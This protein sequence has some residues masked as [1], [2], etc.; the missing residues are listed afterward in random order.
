MS[1][2]MEVT[3]GKSAPPY[4]S[5]K[6]TGVATLIAITGGVPLLLSTAPVSAF[7][8]AAVSF[9]AAL[10]CVWWNPVLFP[11]PGVS[12][13]SIGSFLRGAGMGAGFFLFYLYYFGTSIV[14]YVAYSERAFCNSAI[15]VLHDLAEAEESYKVQ[16]GRYGDQLS[17]VMTKTTLPPDVTVSILQADEISFVAE[18]IH[19]DCKNGPSIWDSSKGGLQ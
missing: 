7:M 15:N 2:K 14:P 19:P 11:A 6:K 3:D 16:H 13:F 1:G 12:R 18:A 10:I 5:L 8:M 4:Q 9:P 17:A